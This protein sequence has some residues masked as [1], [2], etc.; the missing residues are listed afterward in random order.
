[1]GHRLEEPSDVSIAALRTLI[2][3]EREGR[4]EQQAL[5]AGQIDQAK[6][7]LAGILGE[8]S[9]GVEFARRWS[10]LEERIAATNA[11]LGKINSYNQQFRWP[12]DRPLVELAI[13]VESV[14]DITGQ[15]IQALEAE[16]QADAIRDESLARKQSIESRIKTSK[17]Q[18]LPY[19]Q[20]QA[21]LGDIQATDSL[22]RALEDALNHN[23]DG[24][25][26]IFSRIHAPAEFVS[27]GKKATTLV[28]ESGE[29]V[30]LRQVSTGQR[31]AFALSVFLAQNGVLVGAPPVMLIDDPVAHTDDLNSLA[32]LDYLRDVVLQGNRQ[33]FFATADHGLA[34]L[35][36]R[37][38]DFLGPEDFRRFD[39][40]RDPIASAE[41]PMH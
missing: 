38:F 8:A 33:I 34:T 30:D 36:T 13:E 5:V 23:R 26:K 7:S 19:E 32:F 21:V 25:Q 2:T 12:D 29:E 17:A 27:L 40:Y 22:E 1:M 28:R 18:N 16:Q 37:K 39:L 10:Q 14:L 24:I 4:Q 9:N 6:E 35:F 3:N 15:L 11:L 41:N 20:A 31:A